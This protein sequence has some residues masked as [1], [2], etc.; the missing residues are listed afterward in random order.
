MSDQEFKSILNSILNEESNINTNDDNDNDQFEECTICLDMKLI[1][2]TYCGCS[3]KYCHNCYETVMNNTGIICTVCKNILM[4]QE[5]QVHIPNEFDYNDGINPYS[6][7]LYPESYQ[8]SG[9]VNVSKISDTTLS[10]PKESQLYIYAQSYNFLR[11]M[12]GSYG[13]RYTN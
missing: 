13:L 11:I 7:A 12:D 4:K 6:F 10:F 9:N 2:K 1:K 3:T 5:I 8:P